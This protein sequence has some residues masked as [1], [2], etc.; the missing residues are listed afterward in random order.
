MITKSEIQRIAGALQVAPQIVDHDYA[1]GCFLT[2]LYEQPH[3]NRFLIFKGGTA[4]AKC[5]FRNYRF[6]ED[7]DFTVLGGLAPDNVVTCIDTA[8][9]RM[10]ASVGI[11][12]S[13]EN[14]HI[15]LVNDDYGKESIEAR[16]YYQSAWDYGGSK[17]K[18]LLH[19]NR[20]ETL[21]FPPLMLPLFH[22]YSDEAILPHSTMTVYAKEEILCEKLRAFCGQ[23][24]HAIARDIFDMYH[25]IRTDVDVA[26][27]LQAFPQKCNVKSI[28]WTGIEIDSILKRKGEYQN[29]WKNNLEYLVPAGWKC[30][31]DDAWEAA[32]ELLRKVLVS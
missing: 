10:F 24:K 19:L 32:T 18:I 27:V 30:S 25:L 2:F 13:H 23:R 11:E 1:L 5:Y 8:A 12:T 14:I 22:D 28:D 17:R 15:E 29:N 16:V 3:V 7:L 4:L 6:S 9:K 26:S 20:D 31:F 21:V